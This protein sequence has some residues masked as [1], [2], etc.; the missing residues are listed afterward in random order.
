M[1]EVTWEKKQ[2]KQDTS[3]WMKNWSPV[4]CSTWPDSG[5]WRTFII[6]CHDRRAHS[7]HLIED[8]EQDDFSYIEE[9][10]GQR[11]AGLF[12]KVQRGNV[13]QV[14]FAFFTQRRP[15]N[16]CNPFD[17]IAER[18]WERVHHQ[19]LQNIT[20]HTEVIK[21]CDGS[22][23]MVAHVRQKATHQCNVDQLDQPPAGHEG[24]SQVFDGLDHPDQ[25]HRK[26]NRSQKS[27]IHW[28]RIVSRAWP[29]FLHLLFC[30]W[31]QSSISWPVV[32]RGPLCTSLHCFWTWLDREKFWCTVMDRTC[33]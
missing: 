26:K 25:L 10:R 3:V 27:N 4:V 1:D 15:R 19:R 33:F 16:G 6:F 11:S 30:H 24:V 28:L 9:K 13:K 7:K 18:L 29:V 12:E 23:N 5:R 2:T 14:L 22:K 8:V 21:V 17:F 31:S 20:K 32:S